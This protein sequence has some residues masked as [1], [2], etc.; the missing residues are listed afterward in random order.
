MTVPSVPVVGP[1]GVRSV[2]GRRRLAIL[3]RLAGG[4][5]ELTT[6][7]LCEVCAEVTAADGA[8]IMLMW[9][10]E[11]RGSVATTD[12]VA[13]RMEDL[14]YTLGEGPCLD[15]YHGRHPV[16]EADLANPVTV[17]WPG[18]SAGALAW[19]VRAIFGFPLQIGAV[20]LGALN[21]YRSR[22]GPLSDESH[23]N[24]LVAADVVCEALLSLQG[25]APANTLS[26]DLE[27]SANFRYLVAQASGMISVQLNISI[28]EALLRLRAYAFAGDRPVDDIAADIVDR[29]LRFEEHFGG[30]A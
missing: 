7:H 1:R 27:V 2:A 4:G 28:S 12:A 22:P 14:Q 10:D 16:L 18:F 5:G 13:A 23:A 20:R 30:A 6:A 25:M 17:R 11:A 15:A 3:T 29:R 26:A 21:L 8:G 9:G 24:A 19:G